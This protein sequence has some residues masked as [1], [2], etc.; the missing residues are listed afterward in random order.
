MIGTSGLSV[1]AFPAIAAHAAAGRQAELNGELAHALRLLA[2]LLV[3]IGIGLGLFASPVVRLLFEHGRFTAADSQAVA[4]LL[5]LYLGAIYGA[6]LG[7]V[8]SRTLYA[9]HD[10][11]TPVVVST[12]VFT[13]AIGLKFLLV[14]QWQAAGLAAA[15]SAYF[16]L[17]SLALAA[18]LLHRRG[19]D[20][21]AGVGTSLARSVISALVACGAAWLAGR[22]WTPFA[23]LPAA[24]AGA[25]V[26]AIVARLLGDEFM[27]LAT[28]R[29]GSLWRRDKA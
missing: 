9:L 29:A 6:G 23:V 20:M 18:I 21:L 24:V 12:V 13:I 5:V 17:N 3:P 16:V 8:L 19:S 25:I 26:Y 2:F 10:T 15:T 11:R 7:D 27:V 28:A 4:V 14:Q 1:V 22:A